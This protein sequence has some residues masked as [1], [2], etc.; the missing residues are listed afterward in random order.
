LLEADSVLAAEPV[1]GLTEDFVAALSSAGLPTDDL[2]MPGRMFFRFR[3]ADG[4]AAGFGGYELYG[5]DVLIRSVIVLPERRDSGLGSEI[6]ALLLR[7]ASAAGAMQ[8]FLLTATARTFFE[9]IGFAVIARDR[10]PPAILATRE[11]TEL[12]PSSA[13]LLWR[14]LIG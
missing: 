2:A 7:K 5:R 11:A 8:A 13:P 6:V 10:V 1:D 3:D 12:C 4:T 9:R 14:S